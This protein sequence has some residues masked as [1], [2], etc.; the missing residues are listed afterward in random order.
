MSPLTQSDPL[1]QIHELNRLF[2]TVLQCCLQG[3]GDCLGLPA[4]ARQALRSASGEL[5]DVVAQFPRALF[6]ITLREP[7]A[8]DAR[9]PLRSPM[10]AARH[11]MNAMILLCAWTF[12]R[13]SVYQ[14]RFLLGL[15]SRVIQQLRA[16]QL[17]DVQRFS[18]APQLVACAFANSEWLWIELLTETRPEARRQLAL[19]ALQP[20]L[21][22]EWPARRSAHAS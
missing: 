7:A 13:Q 11:S 22:R 18:A 21:E 5:L 16:L 15:E 4:G 20:G 14:A 9:S 10:E 2:L 6:Q 3:K 19:I 8:Q 12:S 17:T 1:E